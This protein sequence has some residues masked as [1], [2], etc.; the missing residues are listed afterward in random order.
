[1]MT[2]ARIH[3]R[4]SDLDILGHVNNSVYLSYFEIARVHYFGELLGTSWDWKTFTVVLVKNEIEYLKPIHLHDEV[5]VH[6]HASH[7]G[8][9]SF[10]V[11]YKVTVNEVLHSRGSSVLVAWDAKSNRTMPIH[12]SMKNALEQLISEQ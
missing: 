1:M 3:V 6:M 8:E 5:F 9:K 7:I 10:T 12:P 4:F 11:E 2:P